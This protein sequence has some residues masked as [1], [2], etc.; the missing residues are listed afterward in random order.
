MAIVI[1]I[2]GIVSMLLVGLGSYIMMPPSI[3]CIP[4]MRYRLWTGRQE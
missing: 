3:R 4:V 2:V 1:I